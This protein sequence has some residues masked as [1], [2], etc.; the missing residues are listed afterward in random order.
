[1]KGTTTPKLLNSHS[2][3]PF[4]R[5]RGHVGGWRT[6]CHS[7]L[8]VFVPEKSI[9][10]SSLDL[11][12]SCGDVVRARVQ[13]IVD[14]RHTDRGEL[15]WRHAL[16]PVQVPVSFPPFLE[17]TLLS[18]SLQFHNQHNPFVFSLQDY[19]SYCMSFSF[20]L[21]LC[22]KKVSPSVDSISWYVWGRCARTDA[23][24]MLGTPTEKSYLGVTLS[25]VN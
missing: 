4:A 7:L 13:C 15:S 5:Y 14:A 8:F 10:F 24:S 25:A 17:D 6:I 1:M 23:L 19:S 2:C 16:S 22:R 21:F 20:C 3:M 9:A 11:V 12:V 18:I